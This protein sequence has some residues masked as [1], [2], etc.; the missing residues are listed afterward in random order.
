MSEY[1]LSL[2]YV[3]EYPESN[4][5]FSVMKEY[6]VKSLKPQ[7]RTNIQGI[8]IQYVKKHL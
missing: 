3:S 8:I 4:G 7:K 5:N 2:I 1:I 6:I